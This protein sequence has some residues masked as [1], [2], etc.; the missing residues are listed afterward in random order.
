MNEV[1]LDET[2]EFFLKDMEVFPK[3][4]GTRRL[5][6]TWRGTD[7]EYTVVEWM[8]LLDDQDTPGA[9]L[10][11]F[12]KLTGQPPKL[13]MHIFAMLQMHWNDGVDEGPSY[14]FVYP[15]LSSAPQ[16]A[17]SQYDEGTVKRVINYAKRCATVEEAITKAES[18][19]SEYGD[20][21]RELARKGVLAQV[22][23]QP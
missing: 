1:D 14:E 15:S 16:E 3:R 19:R 9:R 6:L 5:K 7:L 22:V 8:K 10:S 21:A 12:I 4:R 13:G 18:I 23:G 2:H 17:A 20:I 11:S